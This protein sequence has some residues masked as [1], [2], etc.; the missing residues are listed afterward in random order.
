MEKIFTLADDWETVL[1]K[2]KELNPDITDSD[3][4]VEPGKEEDLLE[5]LAAK[6]NKNK[7]EIKAWIESVS[8]TNSI[9]G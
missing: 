6:F 9:A 8:F 1:E 2:I 3:L 4:G 7:S 5:I